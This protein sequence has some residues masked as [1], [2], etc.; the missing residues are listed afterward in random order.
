V[1]RLFVIVFLVSERVHFH[2]S[3]TATRWEPRIDFGQNRRQ[4]VSDT[5]GTAAARLPV[6]VSPPLA[7]WT[8][9]AGK[10]RSGALTKC[11]PEETAG[12]P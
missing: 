12:E 1:G 3:S 4:A 7:D 2:F 8:P 11:I 10:G 6:S 5:K 9:L